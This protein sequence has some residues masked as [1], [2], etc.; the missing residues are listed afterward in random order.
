MLESY[1]AALKE[2]W[3]PSTTHDV[4]GEQLA[5]IA[6]DPGKFLADLVSLEGTI[7]LPDGTEVPKLPSRVRWM[8]DGEFCG[9]INLRWPATGIALPP[10]V[11]G[12]IGYSVVPWKRRR[13]YASKALRHMLVEAREVGLRRVLLTADADNT[14]SQ[15]V[16]RNNG[17]RET[18]T[19]EDPISGTAPK[20]LFEIELDDRR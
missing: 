7:K 5:Q 16:M 15:Q 1:A 11:H 4:S 14:G 10:H 3:S 2:G 19:F 13:G 12:H 9:S 6:A 17:A 20:L 8:W 18:G